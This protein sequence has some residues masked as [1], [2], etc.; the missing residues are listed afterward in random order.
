MAVQRLAQR[1]KPHLGKMPKPPRGFTLAELLIAVVVMVLMMLA[2][3]M[4]ARE[5]KRTVALS[6]NRSRG[7]NTADAIARTIRNDLAKITKNGFL[8]ITRLDPEGDA[9]EDRPYLLFTTSGITQSRTGNYRSLAGISIYGFADPDT[10][11]QSGYT[12]TRNLFFRVPWLCWQSQG[13]TQLYDSVHIDLDDDG[14]NDDEI[15]VLYCGLEN[16][17]T[18]SRENINTYI[19][20]LYINGRV[21]RDNEIAYPP[22]TL[23][24][25]TNSWKILTSEIVYLG[26]QWTDGTVSGGN[27]N[28]FGVS[29]SYSADSKH[30]VTGL[31]SKQWSQDSPYKDGYADNLLEFKEIG[32]GYRALWT[33]HNQNNWPTAIRVRFTIYDPEFE[34]AAGG[35]AVYEVIVPIN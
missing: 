9:N 29:S 13:G 24:D 23:I 14:S 34:A 21:P 25:V 11:T 30:T 26:I 10:D 18:M 7:N 33:H 4:I 6:Q 8:C 5:A 31:P 35:S 1:A 3:G 2:F 22:A 16:I 28:W 19:T 15:D 27:I 12:L 20:N 32:H 17:Q